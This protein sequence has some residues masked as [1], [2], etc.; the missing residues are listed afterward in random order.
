MVFAA[1]F[2]AAAG[3]PVFLAIVPGF[4]AVSAN[5][6]NISSVEILSFDPKSQSTTSLSR[7][8]FAGQ[9]P[10]AITATPDGI[11]STAF[12]PRSL[13]APVA[14]NF[15][16]FPPKTGGRATTAVSIPGRCTSRPNCAAPFAFDGVSNR[17]VG[18]PISVN[19]F[20]FLSG[21]SAG[22]V[23]LAAVSAS[24]P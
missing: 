18:F 11:C 12:T 8:V 9:K 7:P 23:S 21:T 6:R 16:T 22:A 5:S 2:S 19:A 20:A 24:E 15:F 14:S 17:R 3:S 10:S 13:R 4:F 1:V